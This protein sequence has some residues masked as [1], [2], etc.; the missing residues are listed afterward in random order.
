MFQGAQLQKRDGSLVSAETALAGIP[1]VALYFSAHWCPPCRKFTPSLKEFYEEVNDQ[2]KQIEI[3]F[4]SS[5]KSDGAL[6]EYFSEMGDWLCVPFGNESLREELR[7]RFG[8]KVDAN[9]GELSRSG[10]PCMA[11]IDWETEKVVTYE[12]VGDVTAM[13]SMAPEMKW[14]NT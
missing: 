5:D 10:I 14:I 3:V 13:G 12:G 6:S 7:D 2:N 1:R 9:T 11:V 8:K 4:V